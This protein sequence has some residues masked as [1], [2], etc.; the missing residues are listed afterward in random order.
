MPALNDPIKMSLIALLCWSLSGPAAINLCA[1][2]PTQEQGDVIR[3]FTN[4]VQTDVMVFNKEGRVINGLN[5]EDF[6]LKID[7][8]EKPI[9]FFERVTAGSNEEAQLAAARGTSAPATAGPRKGPVPLDGGRTVF[10]YVDD[11]HMDLQGVVATKKLVKRFLDDEMGQNDEVAITSA[12]GQIGFLQQLTDNKVVLS[13]ALERIQVRPY[14]VR[15]MDRP[16]MNEYQAMLIEDND[17][18]VTEYFID[19]TIRLNPGIMRDTAANMV[20]TRA[21]TMLQMASHITLGTLAGLE[22]LI[23][24]ANRLP[25]RKLV[26]FISSGFFLDNR[27]SDARDRLQRITSVAARTGVVIY[28]MD[29]RG[30][31]ATLNDASTE[32]NFDPSGRLVRSTMGELTASQDGMHALAKDTGGRAVFNTNDLKPGLAGALKETSFYYLL[33]WKPERQVNPNSRFHHI[34]VSIP[35]RSD[36]IVRVRRGFFDTEPESEARKKEE[37]TQ[38]DNSAVDKQIQEALAAPY[39]DRHLPIS[40]TLNYLQTPDKG[41]RLSASMQVPAEFLTFAPENG[42]HQAVLTVMGAFFD[43]R[44]QRGETFSGKINVTAGA[45]EVAKGYKR[46]LSYTYPVTVPAG[47]YQVRVAAK[48]EKSGVVGSAHDWVQIPDLTN[49]KLAMSSLLLGE[50]TDTGIAPVSTNTATPNET[51]GLSV[52]HRFKSNSYLRFLVFAYNAIRATNDGMP[53]VAIQI[54]LVRDNQPVLTTSLKRIATEGIADLA[55]LPYAAEIPLQGLPLGFYR[56]HVTMIDRISK[57][58]STQQARFEI[59]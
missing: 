43:E 22:T 35:S 20:R 29:A 39:P 6:V 9:E 52:N 32:T 44:G 28:S 27:N 41:L 37:K 2:N 57:Q 49:G 17:F 21:H 47:L 23:R 19:E 5:R 51:V 34:E 8:K 25:G 11:L 24:R 38:P 4:L 14:N 33:A 55:R 18:E 7:G 1:Q 48:D 59:Y 26:F 15:D 12:S 3:V 53:D 13:T 40:L 36:L 31:V 54:Q 45:A 16:P 56:L 58:S 30:L 50:R 10:F 42:Q 46:D